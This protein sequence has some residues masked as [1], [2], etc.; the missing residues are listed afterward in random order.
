MHTVLITGATEGIGFAAGCRFAERGHQVALNGIVPHAS[1]Q[2]RLQSQPASVRQNLHYFEADLRQPANIEAMITEVE[3]QLASV[4]IVINNAAVRQFEAV[5]DC[6]TDAWDAAL[7]VNLSSAF[8]TARLTIAKMKE[9]GWGR[10]INMS[11]V[12][13]LR[14][15]VNR[16]DYVTTKHALI[17]LTKSIA[18]ETRAYGITC[19]ALCP[20]TV[21]TPQITAR[22]A[23]ASDNQGISLETAQTQYLATRQGSGRFIMPEQIVAMMEFLCSDAACEITG[24]A[25]PIDGGWTAES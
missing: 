9:N 3:S 15:A 7:S 1:M 24:A 21:M 17:G 14:A 4:D 23:A 22:I 5:E 10:I 8:H 2:T 13:G 20:A 11:S 18:L 12:Y 6:T 16:V 19:N 25:L